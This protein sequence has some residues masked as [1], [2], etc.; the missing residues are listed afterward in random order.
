MNSLPKNLIVCRRSLVYFIAICSLLVL[1]I[2]LM[3]GSGCASLREQWDDASN[4]H[5]IEAYEKFLSKHPDGEYAK[6]ARYRLMELYYKK[7]RDAN[8]VA[9]YRQFLNQYPEGEFSKWALDKIV[10]LQWDKAQSS[11]TIAAYQ[12]FLE[13][14]PSGK[15]SEWARSNIMDLYLTPYVERG[16]L[17]DWELNVFKYYW[18]EG[19]VGYQSSPVVRERLN[20]FR[21]RLLTSAVGMETQ[22]LT[23]ELEEIYWL[24]IREGDEPMSYE[25]YLSRYPTGPYA[26]TAQSRLNELEEE[27][28][29]LWHAATK[30]DSLDV[31]LDYVRNTHSKD[32]LHKVAERVLLKA[33]G[34]S[35]AVN[36]LLIPLNVDEGHASTMITWV[37]EQSSMVVHNTPDTDIY[38]FRDTESP[39]ML[40]QE[41]SGFT[42]QE[43]AGVVVRIRG[44]RIDKIWIFQ[45]K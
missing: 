35:R 8:T 33:T 16:L 28:K 26:G 5:T 36:D 44:E 23:S 19:N 39:L 40:A 7:A 18:M 24:R 15:E 17:K 1:G 9:A 25:A 45:G 34:D 30:A 11:N 42:Y 41:Q 43:G 6:R 29:R 37:V 31:Y 10:D 3:I 21:N 2:I 12:E 4:T 38:I 22:D 20:D 14:N 27:E 13:F 32:H